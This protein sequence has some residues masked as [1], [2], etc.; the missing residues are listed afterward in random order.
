[1][2]KDDFDML[3]RRASHY[4]GEVAHPPATGR[5]DVARERMAAVS[6]LMV[7]VEAL[8]KRVLDENEAVDGE[9]Q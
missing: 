2:D 8:L 5:R 1:L 6:L 9:T 3:L 7:V 4:L